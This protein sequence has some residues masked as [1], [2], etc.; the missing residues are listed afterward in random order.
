VSLASQGC[1]ILKPNETTHAHFTL[2]T[3]S[4]KRIG[5]VLLI[6]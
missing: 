2:S 1:F 5:A 3:T 4:N 6:A